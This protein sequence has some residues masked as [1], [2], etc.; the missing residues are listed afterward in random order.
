M[1][2]EVLEGAAK[3]ESL[4]KADAPWSNH[5]QASVLFGFEHWTGFAA[6]ALQDRLGDLR[7]R[8]RLSLAGRCP[9]SPRGVGDR[10]PLGRIDMHDPQPPAVP[11]LRVDPQPGTIG[12]R[13]HVVTP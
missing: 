12:A 7:L 9:W 8:E 13:R 2:E 11:V 4:L 3:R 10:E 6:S 1:G 5:K